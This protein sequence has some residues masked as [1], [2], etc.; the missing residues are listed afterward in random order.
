MNT[1]PND[2]RSEA[3]E[4]MNHDELGEN[5]MDVQEQNGAETSSTS[6]PTRRMLVLQ[7]L[8]CEKEFD[9]SAL[10]ADPS[11]S[12]CGL[13]A[14]DIV[15]AMP[16]KEV[17]KQEDNQNT[18][19]NVDDEQA[20]DEPEL[21]ELPPPAV[22]VSCLLD[23]FNFHMLLIF[24]KDSKTAQGC[25]VDNYTGFENEKELWQ[26]LSTSVIAKQPFAIRIGNFGD[27]EFRQSADPDDF[28]ATAP[29][30]CFRFT[31]DPYNRS[32]KLLLYGF[33]IYDAHLY[34]KKALVCLSMIMEP[35]GHPSGYILYK[36]GRTRCI[37]PFSVGW[38]YHVRE[39]K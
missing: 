16:S 25:V 4:D 18:D 34:G 11:Q 36:I 28:S 2:E 21:E 19:E 30:G 7:C 22:I 23:D 6:K 31:N 37:R 8:G 24:S 20:D 15:I 10:N 14:V 13:C 17:I 1:T 5:M 35:E 33:D 3:G 39:D 27:Q 32:K 12:L 9:S 29:R 26:H 38:L